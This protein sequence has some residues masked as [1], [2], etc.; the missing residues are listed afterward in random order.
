MWP[1]WAC[2][3][4]ILTCLCYLSLYLIVQG[5]MPLKTAAC[6]KATYGQPLGRIV[7]LLIVL[8]RA[9]Q[10]KQRL[11][12]VGACRAR[13]VALKQ[14]SIVASIGHAVAFTSNNKEGVVDKIVASCFY[15]HC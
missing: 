4:I 5:I 12:F 11:H 10:G 14:Y 9:G 2:L 1:P 8:A 7:Q 15:P 13:Q 6:I 3:L